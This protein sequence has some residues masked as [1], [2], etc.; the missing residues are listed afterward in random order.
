MGL[1]V[2]G[3]SPQMPLLFW[4]LAALIDLAT[5]DHRGGGGGGGTLDFF[6]DSFEGG[7]PMPENLPEDF[8]GWAKCA[9]VEKWMNM[10][11]W[12]TSCIL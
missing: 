7:P 4:Q 8:L 1:V 10:G 12:E 11:T 5:H 3:Q 9:K 2:V 6:W